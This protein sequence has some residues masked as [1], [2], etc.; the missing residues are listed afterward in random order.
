[1]L[2]KRLCLKHLKVY[3]DSILIMLIM[4]RDCD[5]FILLIKK[6][7]QTQKII[8]KWNEIMKLFKYIFGTKSFAEYSIE[9]VVFIF[10]FYLV[11]L[12]NLV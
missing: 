3:L 9:G 8:I 7:T 12:V 11:S 4:W 5:N 2:F 6:W 1:M 10:L